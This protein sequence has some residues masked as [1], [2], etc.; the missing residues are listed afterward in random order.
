M[1]TA[2][3]EVVDL[4]LTL[5]Y[6]CWIRCVRRAFLCGDDEYSGKNFDHRKIWIVERI[7]LLGSLF[8]ID[9]CAYAIMSNHLHVVL[10]AMPH[11]VAKWSDE[12]VLA[13]GAV[14]PAGPS[15]LP[16]KPVGNVCRRSNRR[17]MA[18]LTSPDSIP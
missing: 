14:P 12:E 16:Q 9:V 6:H 11:V 5:F 13:L 8:A 1:T 2:R 7:K 10:R 15:Y 18:T 17:P 3:S 4:D